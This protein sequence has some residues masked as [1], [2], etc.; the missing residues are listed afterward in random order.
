MITLTASGR[1]AHHP[2]LRMGRQTSYCEFRLL[3]TR[4]SRGQEFTEAVTFFCFS[5]DAE[6][7]CQSVEKGQWVEATGAQETHHW[8][9]GNG[10]A[11]TSVKYQLTWWQPGARPARSRAG[12][13]HQEPAAR[14]TTRQ[15]GTRGASQAEGEDGHQ[16]GFV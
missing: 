4:Y 8:T 1:L 12:D 16:S 6:R 9:D 5:D 15:A 13:A 14:G 7:F 3:S 11:K 10:V 2:E